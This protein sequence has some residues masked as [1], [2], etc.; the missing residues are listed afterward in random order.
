[1]RAVKAY[2][3]D[4]IELR[5]TKPILEAS[6]M[7]ALRDE[8]E[9]LTK[10]ILEELHKTQKWKVVSKKATDSQVIRDQLLADETRTD[11]ELAPKLEALEKLIADPKK[12]ETAAIEADPKIKQLKLDY[13][14]SLETIAELRRKIDSSKIDAD[15]DVKS[16]RAIVEGFEG[17]L[18]RKRKTLATL[19]TKVA[20]AQANVV[21][22]NK[23]LQQ[24]QAADQK[25]SNKGN[26]GKNG[27]G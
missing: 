14:Q 11:E 2:L 26:K 18:N 4:E 21:E 8:I 19:N 9:S 17:E 10:P 16:F 1:M 12:L 3:R 22:A 15:P 5:L 6:K 24:A 25:D 23:K 27:R 20:N 7:R 13:H